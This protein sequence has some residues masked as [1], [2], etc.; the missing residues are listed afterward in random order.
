[1]TLTALARGEHLEPPPWLYARLARGSLMR[2]IYRRLIHDLA[3]R[4][5]AGLTLR[6]PSIQTPPP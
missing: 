4:T 3:G 5:P 2:L 6:P 1:M